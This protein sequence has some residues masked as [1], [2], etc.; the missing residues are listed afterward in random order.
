M[1]GV[2]LILMM[3][4]GVEKVF[5]LHHSAFEGWKKIATNIMYDI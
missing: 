4:S 1:K 2:I 3:V 5:R